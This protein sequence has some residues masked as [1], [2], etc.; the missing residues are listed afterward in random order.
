MGIAAALQHQVHE[1]GHVLWTASPQRRLAAL[2]MLAQVP[3]QI[4]ISD[5]LAYSVLRSCVVADPDI[6]AAALRSGRLSVA[7]ESIPQA[8]AIKWFAE[9][10]HA[11]VSC[12]LN[13]STRLHIHICSPSRL[14]DAV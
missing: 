4:A 6:A 10:I 11:R 14:D 9:L 7:I 5:S 8:E 1:D 13:H 3:V 2:N 12:P